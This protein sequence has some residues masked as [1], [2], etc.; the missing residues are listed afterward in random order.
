MITIRVDDTRLEAR[1]TERARV[2]GKSAEQIAQELLAEA[3]ESTQ[4]MTLSFQKLDP[5]QHSQR[6]QFDV[7]SA[8]D[9]APAFQHVT[10]TVDYANSLR[11]NAWKR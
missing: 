4:E 5:R 7:D 6:L 2:T 10:D 9:D 1:L 3:L 11:Q 8:T